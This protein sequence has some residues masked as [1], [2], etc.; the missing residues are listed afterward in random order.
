MT[1]M[2]PTTDTVV[3]GIDPGGRSTGLCLIIGRDVVE[4]QVVVNAAE[5]MLPIELTYVHEVLGAMA[6]MVERTALV[7]DVTIAVEDVVRP[8]WHMKGRAAADPSALLATA[9]ILGA[10]VAFDPTMRTVL[11]RP[12]GNGS[13]ALGEYPTA[14]VSAAERRKDGWRTRIG[15]GQLR[16]ARSAYDVAL[17]GQEAIHA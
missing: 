14:L 1:I 6:T 13:R 4:H 3:L 2:R 15:T 12:R 8:S 17:A 9:Q 5:K 11:V 10:C 7:V 16:H